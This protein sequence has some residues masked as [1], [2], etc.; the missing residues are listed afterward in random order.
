[1]NRHP[2]DVAQ[3]EHVVIIES[4]IGLNNTEA[5]GS[6]VVRRIFTWYLSENTRGYKTE[7]VRP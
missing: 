6:N 5:Y 2:I 3:T 7:T 1:M 4:K